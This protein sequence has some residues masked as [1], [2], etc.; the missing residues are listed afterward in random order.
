MDETSLTKSKLDKEDEQPRLRGIDSKRQPILRVK[1]P[2]LFTAV[3]VVIFMAVVTVWGVRKVVYS[4]RL[5]V[6]YRPPGDRL[7]GTGALCYLV[8][9]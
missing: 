7:A 1:Y 9:L 8:W 6:H 5:G 2:F 3:L 4:D